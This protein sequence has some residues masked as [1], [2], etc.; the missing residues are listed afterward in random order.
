[1]PVIAVRNALMTVGIRAPLN[2]GRPSSL[3]AIRAGGPIAVLA[4]K[5]EIV[6]EPTEDDL[7]R[8]GCAADVTDVIATQDR[9]TWVV[10]R[11]FASIELDAIVQTTPYLRARVSPFVVRADDSPTYATSRPSFAN[12]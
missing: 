2:I 5:S 10:I 3:A 4:Q 12:G 9:G 8:I 6:E 11:T 1:M 7:H